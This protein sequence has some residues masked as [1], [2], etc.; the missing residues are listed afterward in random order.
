MVH[1]IPKIFYEIL[2]ESLPFVNFRQVTTQQY[3]STAS[4]LYQT[5]KTEFIFIIGEE[6]IFHQNRLKKKKK[7]KKL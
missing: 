2:D 5:L 3:Q 4:V 1:G 6:Q 7:K